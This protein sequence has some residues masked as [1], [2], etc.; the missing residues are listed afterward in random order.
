MI[1]SSKTKIEP[2][3]DVDVTP[4]V[5]NPSSFINNVERTEIDQYTPTEAAKAS[6][7]ASKQTSEYVK[8]SEKF[9]LD[10]CRL[11]YIPMSMQNLFGPDNSTCK[12]IHSNKL[13]KPDYDCILRSGIKINPNQS[14]LECIADMYDITLDRLKFKIQ[15]Y[16]TIDA[17]VG[18]Q[19]GN[20][21]NAFYDPEMDIT[22]FY[23]L[24][25][26]CI[27]TSTLYSLLTMDDDY[28]EMVLAYNYTYFDKIFISYVNFLHNYLFRKNTY[29]DHTFMWDIILQIYDVN[30]CIFEI[31]SN[32]SMETIDLLCPPNRYSRQIL[33]TNT[34]YDIGVIVKKQN[35]YEPIYII[36][37]CKKQSKRIKFFNEKQTKVLY[38]VNVLNRLLLELSN[39]CAIIDNHNMSVYELLRVLNSKN[40]IITHK[41]MDYSTK[42]IGLRTYDPSF[43]SYGIVTCIPSVII[44]HDYNITTIPTKMVTSNTVWAT[45]SETVIFYNELIKTFENTPYV[46]RLPKLQY[47]ITDDDDCI[48]GIITNTN[49]LISIT[50]RPVYTSTIVSM[51]NTHNI[52]WVSKNGHIHQ[53]PGKFMTYEEEQR[54]SLLNISSVDA[55]TNGQLT[56]SKNVDPIWNKSIEDERTRISNNIIL[57]NTQYKLFRNVVKVLLT[58]SEMVRQLIDRII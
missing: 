33:R 20:L 4:I 17:Y 22:S 6:K 1:Q 32:N 29:I 57:E 30:L 55:E 31:S 7:V 9:P 23:D 37:T 18:L 45:F 10:P 25:T 54:I 5:D 8:N 28:P 42:I 14:F 15:S 48:N 47:V 53:Y 13:L 58:R 41:I 50:D 56:Y 34:S 38:T 40:Y 21:V 12:F 43:K 35:Y 27:K 39:K 26:Q 19:N 2:L 51:K 49:Q 46:N 44:E 16:L 3:E 11:G 24:Y 36:R 52:G